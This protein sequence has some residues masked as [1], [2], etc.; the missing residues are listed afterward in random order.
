MKTKISRLMTGVALLAA[1]S[2]GL[3]ACAQQT[4]TGELYKRVPAKEHVE[5]FPEGHQGGQGH[6]CHYDDEADVYFCSY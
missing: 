5:Q 3:S 1:L 4:S 2:L 6:F